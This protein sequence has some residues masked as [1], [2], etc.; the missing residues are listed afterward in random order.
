MMIYVVDTETTTTD[1]KDPKLGGRPN[2]HIVEL[3]MVSLD[4]ISGAI[5]NVYHCISKSP[6]L[7]L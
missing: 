5:T 6:K 7:R 2:G 3:G 1:F 4:T